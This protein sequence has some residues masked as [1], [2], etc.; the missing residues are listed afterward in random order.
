M[1]DELIWERNYEK[2]LDLTID[3]DLNFNHHFS[4]LC[5]EMSKKVSA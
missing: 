4:I 2:L 1:G 3:K 5:K